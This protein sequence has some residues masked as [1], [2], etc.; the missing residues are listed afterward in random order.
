MQN[1]GALLANGADNHMG[2]HHVVADAGAVD[3]SACGTAVANIQTVTGTGAM[4]SALA[5][6]T[7]YRMGGRIDGVDTV[8]FYLDG[9]PVSAAT[10]LTA[11]LADGLVPTFTLIAAGSAAV[12]SLDYF[13]VASSRL[14][15]D[16]IA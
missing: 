5:V 1:D 2:F 13:L 8:T 3:L 11:D 14:S 10:T 6:D 9:L 7:W 4:A 16:A 15:T 12:M